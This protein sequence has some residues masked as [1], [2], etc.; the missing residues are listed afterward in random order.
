MAVSHCA[1]KLPESAKEVA[2]DYWMATRF[3]TVRA[4]LAKAMSGYTDPVGLFE[5]LA[6]AVVL[7]D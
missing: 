3:P 7:A 2:L 1:A 6:P 4:E 5:K